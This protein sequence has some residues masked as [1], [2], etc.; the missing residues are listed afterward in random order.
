MVG[1]NLKS[2]WGSVRVTNGC[3]QTFLS[4]SRVQSKILHLLNI[5]YPDEWKSFGWELPLC[6]SGLRTQHNVCEDAGLITG[7]TKWVK[8]PALP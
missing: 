5:S 6:L 3:E 7:L 4:I 8:G 2:C 1:P